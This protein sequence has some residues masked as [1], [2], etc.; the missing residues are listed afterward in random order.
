[1]HTNKFSVFTTTTH[2]R[3]N[4]I[5]KSCLAYRFLPLFARRTLDRPS[6]VTQDAARG[7]GFTLEFVPQKQAVRQGHQGLTHVGREGEEMFYYFIPRHA[8]T[9]TVV[10]DGQT[11]A[12][13]GTGWYDHEFGGTIKPAG[14]DDDK[15]AESGMCR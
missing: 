9:G 13:A 3:A 5:S 12:V 4:I 7:L 15:P 14:A 11:H 6:P 2:T 8:V 10:L 1:M